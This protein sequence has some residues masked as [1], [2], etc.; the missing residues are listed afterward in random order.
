MH[1]R[2]LVVA[3]ILVSIWFFFTVDGPGHYHPNHERPPPP[4][5]PH[6]GESDGEKP[7]PHSYGALKGEG[8]LDLL[9]M[10]QAKEYCAARRWEAVSI[11]IRKGLLLAGSRSDTE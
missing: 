10:D 7:P 4:G 1:I 11:S 6:W 5:R 9:S 8:T 3:T 2:F